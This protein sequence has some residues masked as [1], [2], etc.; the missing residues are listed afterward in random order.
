MDNNIFRKKSM[1][2]VTNPEQLNDYIKVSNPSVWMILMAIIF[3][4]IGVCAWGYFGRLET[5][6]NVPCEV[7]NGKFEAFVKEDDID[8]LIEGMTIKI[9]DT[10][11]YIEKISGKAISA[12]DNLDEYMM[13]LGD[14]NED[15]WVF[16][17]TG[18]ISLED[19]IYLA[20]VITESITPMSFVLN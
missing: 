11:S 5:K 20:E 12:K 14:I 17:I 3:F 2:R 15:E 1:D 6:I 7:V 13:H 9:K 18:K 4:L 16:R 19:G 10:E 8:K